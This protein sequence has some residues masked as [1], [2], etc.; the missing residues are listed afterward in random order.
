MSCA[1]TGLYVDKCVIRCTLHDA[2]MIPEQE[3]GKLGARASRNGSVVIEGASQPECVRA[4]SDLS[5]ALRAEPNGMSTELH[6]RGRLVDGDLMIGRL[7]RHIES[8][9]GEST[10]SMTMMTKPTTS[11]LCCFRPLSISTCVDVDLGQGPSDPEGSLVANVCMD[12]NQQFHVFSNGDVVF[13]CSGGTDIDKVW[14]AFQR[15]L[16]RVLG[17]VVT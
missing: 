7:N 4:L 9:K 13:T 3:L 10:K 14:A 12:P 16:Q 2:W 15:R 11:F 17:S 6:V 1:S 8:I 5:R